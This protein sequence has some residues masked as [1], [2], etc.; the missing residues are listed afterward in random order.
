MD[1]RVF[2]NGR[3]ICAKTAGGS[4][5]IAVDLCFSPGAPLPGLPVPRTSLCRAGDLAGGSKTVFIRGG[6]AGIEDKS[7]FTT[8]P[9]DEA[10][11]PGPRKGTACGGAPGRNRFIGWSANVFVEGAAVTRHLDL[12]AHHPATGPTVPA[13]YLSQA[14]PPGLPAHRGAGAPATLR[15]DGSPLVLR[16]VADGTAG[17][18]AHHGA[19][20]GANPGDD[21]A[22]GDAADSASGPVLRMAPAGAPHG[23]GVAHRLAAALLKRHQG[24]PTMKYTTARDELAA[25]MGRLQGRDP[26]GLAAEL[27]EACRSLCA[28]SSGDPV[29]PAL[30]NVR[31]ATQAGAT[32]DSPTLSPA[33][34]GRRRD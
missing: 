14:V 20:P 22:A 12:V 25:L 6:E 31:V 10:A 9:G 29:D 19:D 3:E 33:Q 28:C 8:G 15:D 34:G 4:A 30:A 17:R 7:C 24:A 23:P 16:W 13:P 1:T 5:S 27:D 11:T 26:R 32:G 2:A 18:Q 21:P